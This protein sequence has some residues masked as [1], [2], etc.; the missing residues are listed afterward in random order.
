MSGPIAASM[1]HPHFPPENAPKSATLAQI[2]SQK[3]K[4]SDW[5]DA[6]TNLLNVNASTSE[7][8]TGIHSHDNIIKHTKDKTDQY[9]RKSA[10]TEPYIAKY[11]EAYRDAHILFRHGQTLRKD[12]NWDKPQQ[13]QKLFDPEI[14]KN[15]DGSLSQKNQTPPNKKKSGTKIKKAVVQ[16]EKLDI[17]KLSTP[18][19]T[20]SLTHYTEA[21]PPP[22]ATEAPPPPS[23]EGLSEESD[24][25]IE[26]RQQKE[27]PNW[28]TQRKR[29]A[30]TKK[31]SRRP[32]TASKSSDAESNP[33]KQNPATTQIEKPQNTDEEVTIIE[34]TAQI[35]PI[36]DGLPVP[37]VI[38]TVQEDG[39]VV[40]TV[41]EDGTAVISSGT[42]NTCNYNIPGPHKQ[43]V[44]QVG[45]YT[46]ISNNQWVRVPL[47]Q[48]IYDRPIR[49]KTMEENISN[50]PIRVASAVVDNLKPIIEKLGKHPQE[51]EHNTA[52]T[53]NA[54]KQ[55]TGRDNNDVLS[56]TPSDTFSSDEEEH[57]E[58]RP[59]VPLLASLLAELD[60]IKKG[61]SSAIPQ[62][63]QWHKEA[64]PYIHKLMQINTNRQQWMGEATLKKYK[65]DT[66]VQFP[67]NE[68]PTPNSKPTK[69]N[70][71]TTQKRKRQSQ[72]RESSSTESHSTV[73]TTQ[74][75]SS[76]NAS[77]N[78]HNPSRK[79][80]RSRSPPQTSKR[81]RQDTRDEERRTE[82]RRQQNRDRED[83]EAA[84]RR[85][86]RRDREDKEAAEQRRRRRN[87]EERE[88][89]E[90]KRHRRDREGREERYHRNQEDNRTRHPTT[91]GPSSSI[92]P[93][94]PS[95]E[96][97]S[98]SRHTQEEDLRSTL[99][100][101][102]TP[103][104]PS[105][106]QSASTSAPPSERHALA[107]L[108]TTI[109]KNRGANVDGLTRLEILQFLENQL[110]TT[111]HRPHTGIPPRK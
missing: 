111:E 105:T 59:L 71:T 44:S 29:K 48:Y 47:F 57:K 83:K 32:S 1:P 49:P 27:D 2:S 40:A 56:L 46:T 84:E 79:H 63:H 62:N 98:G 19:R 39:K 45:E 108:M 76:S 53:S 33:P 77:S 97:P 106:S 99:D 5:Q 74:S 25:E 85:K 4:P 43:I 54:N 24:T 92:P 64:R 70:T 61:L 50:L 6:P 102:R 78:A 51:K 23:A 26:K 94:P 22:S 69:G 15:A 11:N 60:T 75:S 103:T 9:I 68:H 73:S 90:Q 7:V 12:F 16:V 34:P 91:R 86:Q 28:N 95:R 31:G 101:K 8:L 17:T 3:I 109:L 58:L 89:D 88:A 67:K 65:G 42:L 20:T 10:L 52:E 13:K 35:L 107:G 96:R 110:K 30:P 37:K 41:Q 38:A 80:S 72:S 93:P 82:E 18:P 21:P 87:R 36:S 55:A 81:Q 14:I 100:R 66:L 104:L